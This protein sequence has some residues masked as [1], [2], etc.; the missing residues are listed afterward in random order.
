[1]DHYNGKKPKHV[2]LKFA[3]E[4]K[5]GIVL[6]SEEETVRIISLREKLSGLWMDHKYNGKDFRKKIGD[7]PGIHWQD[8]AI[9]V[10]IEGGIDNIERENM[11]KKII[12]KSIS[13]LNTQEKT[14]SF[15]GDEFKEGEDPRKFKISE[16]EVEKIIES[17]LGEQEVEDETIELK[18]AYGTL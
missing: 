5:D 6:K 7:M 4:E 2:N 14:R 11:L 9:E 18:K 13:D 3:Y 16:K 12:S 15:Y 10:V 17:K 1:M 8:D